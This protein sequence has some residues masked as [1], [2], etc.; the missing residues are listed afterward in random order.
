[1]KNTIL[2]LFLATT[3]IFTACSKAELLEPEPPAGVSLANA[4]RYYGPEGS[5][6]GAS[7]RSTLLQIAVEKVSEEETAGTLSL[8]LSTVYDLSEVT[9]ESSQTLDFAD[10]NGNESTLTFAVQNYIGANGSLEVTFDLG[11]QSLSG[12]DVKTVQ[13]F[14]IEDD[15]F[16]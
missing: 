15:L 10:A 16:H 8:Q 4:E 1:M 11:G 6:T 12:L 7:E 13:S 9:M 3:L 14:I 5:E 2:F